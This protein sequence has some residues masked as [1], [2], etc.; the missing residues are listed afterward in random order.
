VNVSLQTTDANAAPNQVIHGRVMAADGH[1]VSGAVIAIRGTTRNGQATW[2]G[3]DIDYYS[4][5]DNAGNFMIYGRTPFVAVDG[6]VHA[7]GFAEASFEQWPSDAANEEWKRTGS[8]PDGIMPYAKPLHEIVLT[9]GASLGGRLMQSGRPVANAEVRLNGCGTGSGCWKW[10]PAVLTDANG[11]FV[12]THLPPNQSW[13][14]CGTWDLLTRAGAVPE[15]DVKTGENG[16]TQ[17]I[18]DIN[19][20]SVC[21]VAGKIHLSDGKP[22][23]HG[24]V[25]F[26]AWDNMGGSSASAIGEDGSFRFPAVPGENV[27]MYL[28][29]AGYELHP[30]DS[31]L[32]S[33]SVTNITV[34]PQMTD[35][36]IE[37]KPFS[38]MSVMAN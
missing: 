2:P 24:A 32:I 9:E 1:P 37:M 25:Y 28:R 18:G 33:G 13:S 31:R 20:K 14:I 15:T 10:T 3:S 5:S 6:E 23:P 36:E 11:R 38:R 4:V 22:I 34:R 30:G 29:V 17:D 35:L 8:M 21:D 19:L 16:S 26:L 7:D 12:F 27:G